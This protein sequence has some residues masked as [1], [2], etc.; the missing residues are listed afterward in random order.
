MFLG[1]R[2][3]K[4]AEAAFKDFLEP[5]RVEMLELDV[6]SFASVRAAAKTFLSKSSTLNVL[7]NNAGIMACPESKTEDGFESQLQ[8]NYLGHFLL[9]QLLEDTLLKSS[10]SDFNSRVVNVSSAGHQ[11]ST[12]VL[13]NINLEG[14]YEPWK[15]YGNAKTACIWMTN[16]IDRRYGSKGL[17]GLSLM[18]GGIMSDLQSQDSRERLHTCK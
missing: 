17:H 5:G 6:G 15:A 13:N 3:P 11:P 2:S 8:I 1:V 14:E 7:V 18:P 4:K 10:T 12:V 16:E 9:Y